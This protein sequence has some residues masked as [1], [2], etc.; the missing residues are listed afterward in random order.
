MKKSQ[1]ILMLAIAAL[2]VF[3]VSSCDLL[4]GVLDALQDPTVTVIDA[5]TGLPISDAIITLTPLAVEEGKTQVAV[6]ATTSSSGTATFDDV[7]YG[8]YTVTGELTGYVF[9]PFTATVAGWAVNLGTMYAATTAKGT[10][11]NAISIFLTWNSLDLDSWFTYP[12]TFDAANSAEI[13][14]TE[15]G[16]Y[17]LAATGRSKIYH[18]NK[19]S[20]D[21][22]AML[23]V[24]NTD[25]TGPETISVLGNQGPLADSGVGVIPTS[26]SFIMSAL[27]AGNYYYMGAG[28]YYVNAYTAATSL[29]VQDVRVVITQ[30]SSIKGIFN[31]PTNLT[32]ETVSLFRVHYFNDATEA[33]Y[34]MVFVPDFRL[35]GTG[36]TDGQAAIRSLSNDDIF[37]ISGQR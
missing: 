21:T 22:F 9:I 7:T 10:D 27:P 33:N 24:D 8:S 28:E 35:V 2:M 16:Y 18:A 26:T 32:Q 31:L 5:R 13:N 1:K 6:T 23:D 34:Y 4:F 37:V 12:T 29:D 19:G 3:A 17:A 20:T 14:F 30:G 25:G 11:T 36:G 15:D